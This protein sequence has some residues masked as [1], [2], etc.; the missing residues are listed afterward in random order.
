MLAM[1]SPKTQPAKPHIKKPTPRLKRSS[2]SKRSENHLFKFHI[3][4]FFFTRHNLDLFK[5]IWLI[6]PLYKPWDLGMITGLF[7]QVPQIQAYQQLWMT[8]KF[9]Q[10]QTSSN[11]STNRHVFF[12]CL[13][14]P[15]RSLG[16]FLATAPPWAARWRAPS[17]PC[18]WAS[19]WRPRWARCRAR[20]WAPGQVVS[21]NFSA[22]KSMVFV[23]LVTWNFIQNVAEIDMKCW[24]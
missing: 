9:H 5:V 6:S 22:P 11:Q 10:L 7:F 16:A 17:A 24:I 21:V 13:G 20:C 19:A 15:T 4:T 23:Q 3:L 2:N 1:V 18:R 12:Q 8:K 14:V